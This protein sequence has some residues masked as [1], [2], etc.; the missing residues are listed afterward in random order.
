[1]GQKG[2]IPKLSLDKHSSATRKSLV[3][4][5]QYPIELWYV[6]LWIMLVQ[7]VD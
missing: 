7:Q 1:M 5:V 2:M 4:I 3:N 6:T